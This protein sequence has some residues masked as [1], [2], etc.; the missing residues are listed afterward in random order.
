MTKLNLASG[1]DYR[2][3]YYNVDDKS[4]YEGKMKHPKIRNCNV[5]V[6]GSCGFLGSH[7]VNH[8]IDDRKC[9][10]LALDNLIAGKMKFLHPKAKFE[11]CDITHS[12]SELRRYF[13][14][15]KIDYVFN[16]SAEPYI[17]VSFERRNQSYT[18][19]SI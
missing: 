14:K 1:Q 15:Y 7:L 5:C 10:V 11:W 3:D 18:F 19:Q 17:P 4:M 8:L 12:E 6:I 9:M 16:Y 2:E 13:E